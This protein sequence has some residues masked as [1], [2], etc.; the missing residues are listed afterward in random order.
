MEDE[1]KDEKEDEEEDEDFN[2]LVFT[3]GTSIFMFVYWS[4]LFANHH[5]YTIFDTIPPLP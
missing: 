4:L 3:Q 2:A 5:Y 1:E